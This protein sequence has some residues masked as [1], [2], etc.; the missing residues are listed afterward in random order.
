M[1]I[2][3]GWAATGKSR[4]IG[5]NTLTS[6]WPIIC[7]SERSYL[8]VVSAAGDFEATDNAIQSSSFITNPSSS[9]GLLGTASFERH[10]A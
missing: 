6:T 4:I 3:M 2:L 1:I 9:L 5:P 7:F 8:G 10:W